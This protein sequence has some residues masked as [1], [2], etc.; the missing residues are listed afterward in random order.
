MKE[1][2]PTSYDDIGAMYFKKED[3]SQA[4]SC[5]EKA[6]SIQEINLSLN[7]SS[8]ATSRKRNVWNSQPATIS[9]VNSDFVDGV[10]RT[11]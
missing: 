11:L 6:L 3:Y 7:H 8:V 4:L 2:L 1:P 10:Q 9:R 5:Y